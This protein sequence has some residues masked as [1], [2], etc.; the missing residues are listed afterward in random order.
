MLDHIFI[1]LPTL[2]TERLILR[3]ILYSDKDGIYDYAKNPNVAKFLLWD[4]HRSEFETIEFLNLIYSAY[5]KNDAAPW[6]IQLKDDN[7]II[8]T[9]GFVSWDKE[10]KECEIGFALAEEF[11]NKGIVT[12]AVN[13]VLRF[14]FDQ[15]K[16]ERIISQCSPE[17]I[18]SSRV[19]E[20]SGLNFD[21]I[22]EKK[23]MVKGKPTDMKTY[24]INREDYK[25]NIGI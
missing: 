1:S 18:G 2:E 10:N 23:L 11:W 22:I 8:G 15:M 24:S 9:V 25:I 21:G 6:G 5:N 3:K 14:G 16:L 17:N 20:K 7:K 12:E 19:L 13:E 4:A